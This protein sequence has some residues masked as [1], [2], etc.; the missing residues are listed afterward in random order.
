MSE[1]K[2]VSMEEKLKEREDNL[3]KDEKV[4][5]ESKVN[6][7]ENPTRREIIDIMQQVA[8]EMNQM[9]DYL[10]QDVNTMYSKH[11]FPFQLRLAAIEEILVKKGILTKE[12]VDAEVEDRYKKLEA[13]AKE[14][15]E[16]ENEKEDLP[17][18]EK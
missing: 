14:I 7:D 12:E 5:E 10:M 18:E 11:V 16:K 2:I 17:S 15:M 13:Q 9:A 8:D 1:E 3:D 6:L 4:E